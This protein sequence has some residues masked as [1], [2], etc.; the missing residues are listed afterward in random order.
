MPT[1]S[2]PRHQY[3]KTRRVLRAHPLRSCCA[4]RSA[5]RHT[6]AKSEAFALT[7]WNSLS[8]ENLNSFQI[9]NLPSRFPKPSA[10]NPLNVGIQPVSL[11]APANLRCKT[12]PHL[13]PILLPESASTPP[14]AHQLTQIPPYPSD[15]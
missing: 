15:A 7:M 9:I 4:R 14:I 11:V 12:H 8:S 3:S 13:Q 10:Q 6:D 2:D 1:S 5:S